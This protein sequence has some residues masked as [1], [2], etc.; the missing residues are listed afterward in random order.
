MTTVQE[1]E[2]SLV[3]YCKGAADG[4]LQRC[5]RQYRNGRELPFSEREKNCLLYTSFEEQCFLI[6]NPFP[7]L[8]AVCPCFYMSGIHE[9]LGRI[10]QSVFIAFLQDTG[11][12]LFKKI[13]IR[14]V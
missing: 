9:D 4:I 1:R 3:A 5:S 6:C 8:F 11:K 2:G 10:D 14:C 12:D 13:S 7:H